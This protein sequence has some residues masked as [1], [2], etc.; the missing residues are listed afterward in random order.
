MMRSHK[1][2]GGLTRGRGIK[3][4][5][6]TMW[7]CSSYRCAGIQK[8]M[9]NLTGIK[10]RSSEQH[11]ALGASRQLGDAADLEKLIFGIKIGIHSNL[12]W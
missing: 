4:T 11:I 3:R 1:G 10:H 7:I 6:R 2:R 12:L 5:V 9:I 8:A